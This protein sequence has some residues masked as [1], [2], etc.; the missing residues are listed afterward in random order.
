MKHP[1][2]HDETPETTHPKKLKIK[3]HHHLIFLL[4]NYPNGIINTRR[5][6][7]FMYVYTLSIAYY[8]QSNDGFKTLPS[9]IFNEGELVRNHRH[10]KNSS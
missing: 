7:V 4:F 9:D 5:S 2:P 8:H 10:E 3:I 1:K 6:Y